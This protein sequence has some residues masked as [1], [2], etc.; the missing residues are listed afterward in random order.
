MKFLKWLIYSSANPENVSRTVKTFGFLAI[1]TII[2]IAGQL[3]FTLDP[4]QLEA[5]V[6]SISIIVLGV[7]TLAQLA[8]KLY[9]TYSDKEVVTFTK[10]KKK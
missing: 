1:P 6:N 10:T 5:Y 4:H 7:L 8:R 2:M 9:N 3:N